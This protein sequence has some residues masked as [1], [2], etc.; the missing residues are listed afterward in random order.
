MAIATTEPTS[1]VAGD[2]V[3]WTR[4]L[5][6]YPAPTYV[7]K[8]RFLNAAGKV[9][10]TATASGTDHAVSVTAATT[11]AWT[12]GNY[13]WLAWV[14][15]GSGPTAERYSVDEGRITVEPNRA[16]LTIWDGRSDARQI[17]EAL[18]TAWK[19][20]S[21]GRAFVGEYEIAGRRMKF[22]NKADWIVELDYWKAQ[23]A[24]E[25]RAEAIANGMASG[26]RLLVRM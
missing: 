10:I 14:E 4:S 25:D 8:Y 15:T 13:D 26:S 12:A 19:S 18:V 11:A 16:A 6:D 20:A 7:L 21:I 9:D 22:N 24:S 5:A 23:V 3:A 2:T 17:Y 1:V